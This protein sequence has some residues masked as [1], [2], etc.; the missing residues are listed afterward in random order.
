M[1]EIHEPQEIYGFRD[2]CSGTGYTISHPAMRKIVSSLL[3]IFFIGIIT[4][5]SI[6]F[7]VL[8]NCL[9]LN[10]WVLR[11]VHSPLGVGRSKQVAA[12]SLLG[13]SSCTVLVAGYWV[14]P[15]QEFDLQSHV[16]TSMFSAWQHKCESC[17]WCSIRPLKQ[18]F[19]FLT[20]KNRAWCKPPW[21]PSTQLLC[22]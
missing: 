14:K 12:W 15:H 5:T 19:C 3:C 8:L 11:F 20:G 13:V 21:E 18:V 9:Y 17:A 6:T 10:P 4:I 22:H 16:M 2:H 7:L 1:G